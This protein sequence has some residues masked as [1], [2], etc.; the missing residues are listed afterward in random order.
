MLTESRLPRLTRFNRQPCRG[1][2]GSDVRG[3]ECG[4]RLQQLEAEQNTDGLERFCR[5]QV[6]SERVIYAD[7]AI[8]GC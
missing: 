5:G 8:L 3:N 2:R 7:V 6:L 4:R 1:A